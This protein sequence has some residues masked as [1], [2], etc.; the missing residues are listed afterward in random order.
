MFGFTRKSKRLRKMKKVK[1][2]DGHLLK[3]YRLWNIFT[4]SLFHIQI[5]ND[6]TGEIENYAIR[7]RYFVEEPSV[8]LYREGRH[9]A[10]SKLPAAFP[11]DHGVIEI[12]TSSSGING[13]HYMSDLDDTFSIY[14]EKRSI[15][16]LRLWVHRRF[17]SISVCIGGMAIVTLLISIALSLPQ[18]IETISDIPWVAEN[19]GTFESPII[20]SVWHYFGIG[21]AAA[22]AGTERALML[23]NHWL[24]DIETRNWGDD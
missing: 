5:K 15:R 23:R 4:H 20:L 8:D 17:P 14:P 3:T 13:I 24:I 2:G 22:L 10:F 6:T 19:I 21:I 11:V 12:T 9:V 7:S 16:G 18:L 1:K